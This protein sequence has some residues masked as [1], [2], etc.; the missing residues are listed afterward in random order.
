[1]LI[2]LALLP[3][4]TVVI[5]MTVFSQSAQRAG[6][7]G[8]VLTLGIATFF[9]D[10]GALTH[11][12][13]TT[14]SAVGG[15][16]AESLHTTLSIAWI[17]FPALCIY[18]WQEQTGGITAIRDTL[19]SISSNHTIS[20]IVIAFFFGLFLEGAA[21]FGTPIAVAAPLLLSFGMSPAKAVVAVLFGH[22]MGV[23]FG[24]IGTPVIS[25]VAT[26]GVEGIQ[27]SRYA[28]L[29]HLCVGWI[30]LLFTLRALPQPVN[31]S[32]HHRILTYGCFVVPFMLFAWFVGPE[33]PTVA[34]A[35]IGAVC[36]IAIVRRLDAKE[37]SEGSGRKTS[38]N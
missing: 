12:G 25:Q 31:F 33:L 19:M 6:L 26:L 11:P 32:M 22:A 14:V 21:G 10:L 35:L 20:M 38:G 9:F 17:I 15:I 8:A 1:M 4:F 36:F 3:I 7:I 37:T 23:S 28:A 18:H 5:L 34:G 2:G 30:L 24:A 13:F 29:L 27:I 16:V